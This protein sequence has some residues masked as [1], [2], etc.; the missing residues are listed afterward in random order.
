MS[1]RASAAA[2]AT[3]QDFEII[4]RR[5]G[6]REWLAQ[7]DAYSVG[8][9]FVQGDIEVRGDFVAA[10]R[11]Q[12]Y[13][14]EATLRRQFFDAICRWNPWRLTRRWASRDATARDIRFHYD[15]SNDFYKQF[16]DSQMVYSCAYFERADAS[17]DQAQAAKLDHICRKLGLRPKERF[18]DIGCG[19]GALVLNAARKFGAYAE[20]CTLSHRQFE[21]ASRRIQ[22]ERSTEKVA[23]REMDYLDVAGEFDKISSVGMFE[24]VGRAQ[25]EKY[26]RKVYSLLA[27][28]GL[29]LNHGITRPAPLQ[30]DAQSLFIARTVFPG[31]QIVYLHDVIYAAEN[32]GFE[33]LDVENLR[34]HYALTCRAWVDRLTARREACLQSVDQATWRTWCLYMAGS[35]VAFEQGGLG[36]HQV[37]LAK[38]GAN[39]AAPMTRHHMYPQ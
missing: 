23:V 2:P 24:H 11:Y 7:A 3:A 15:R 17:L 38:R 35:S 8:Q 6:G 9:A 31:G 27:P 39:G 34:R 32:A 18:L 28:G 1:I 16:L 20:G 19:W 25:L 13:R 30:S 12:L 10:V 4:P 5:K 26:F 29:F 37:L 21:Y 22:A 14:S 33:V 36:L